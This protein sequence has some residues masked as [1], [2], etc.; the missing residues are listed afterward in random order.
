MWFTENPWP[1]MIISGLCGLISLVIWNARRQ[2]KLLYLACVFFASTGAIYAMERSIVTEGE[3]LQ[4]DV[5]QMCDQFR[6]RDPRTLDHFADSATEWKATCKLAMEMVEIRDDL[7]LT[8]FRTSVTDLG[9]VGKVHFRANATITAMETTAHHTF[10]CILT[11]EK[12]G[13]DWKIT[14]VERLDPIRG[15][16]MGIMEH[17]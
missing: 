16:S 9:R 4:A 5:V 12:K 6:R 15:D 14:G 3:R 10:R 11:Y 17:R 2:H 8:D 1:P 13:S 7:H